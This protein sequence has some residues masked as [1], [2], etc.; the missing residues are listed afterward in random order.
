MSI[1]VSR[2]N[3]LVGSSATASLALLAACGGSKSPGATSTIQP[4]SLPRTKLT[5]LRTAWTYQDVP[6]DP[7]TFYGGP[8]F[9]AMGGMYEGLVQDQAAAST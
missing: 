7:A 1:T 2:R 5:T 4:T 8:G 9:S 3:F 6:F